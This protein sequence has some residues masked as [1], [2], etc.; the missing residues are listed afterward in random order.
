MERIFVASDLTARSDRAIA[1]AIMLARR[2]GARLTVAHVVD[3]ELP[4]LVAAQQKHEAE[5]ALRQTVDALLG[6]DD[7]Y[8]TIEVPLGEH[9]ETITAMAVRTD[10]SLVV[11][12]K[13][14]S[15]ILLDLFRGSTG[16][17]IIRFGHCPVLV[18]KER[19]THP[20]ISLLAAVDFS[21][22]C[23][24]ALECAVALAPE[25]EVRLVHAVDVPFRGFLISGSGSGELPAKPHQQ[26]DDMVARQ[27]AEFIAGVTP[28]VEVRQVIAREGRAE[29]VILAAIAE[30]RPHLVVVG[31][32]G[33][34]GVSR[35]LLG[36][37]AEAVLARAPCDVLAV[38]GPSVAD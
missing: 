25:A 11:I 7:L 33:R 10:A 8:V 38:H 15:D 9:Y 30:A 22:P 16:E 24:R 27:M 19:V 3:D 34:S 6:P 37:V 17:R 14:R 5:L 1:R 36:S 35:A 4:R 26:F 31:T 18:V 13:H 12:G 28:P 29:D 20:Y 32:H 23:R 21:P 2:H